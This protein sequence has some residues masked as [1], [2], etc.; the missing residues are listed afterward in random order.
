MRISGIDLFL[1]ITYVL[2]ILGSGAFGYIKAK[3]QEDYLV[4]GR[5][6]PL[7]VYIAC[8]STVVIGGGA[9]FGAATQGFDVGLSAMWM[10]T[11]FGVG[12]IALGFLLS[13]KLS[14][15]RIL[16]LSQM[17]E[18]RY[19]KYAS[20][21][22]AI[23]SSFYIIMVAVTNTIALGVAFSV[24][25]GW[26]L[27][28]SI[29]V[30]GALA[31]SYTMLGG[32]TSLAITDT[33]QFTLMTITI[34]FIL[35]PKGFSGVDGWSGLKA[36]LP[37]SYFDL[38]AVG[39][40]KIFSWFILFALGLT[41]GQDIWQR[42]FSAKN[43]KIAKKGTIIGGIYTIL[44]SLAMTL[45]GMMTLALLPSTSPQNA[46]S[47]IVIAIVPS[48]FRGLVF[49]G[50]MSA[51]LSTIAGCMLASSTLILHDIIRIKQHSLAK[52]RWVVIA[53][54]AVIIMVSVFVQNVLTALDITYAILSGCIFIP[55]IAAFF[56]KKANWQGACAS[57]GLSFLTVIGTMIYFTP[58]STIPILLGIS[59]NLITLVV[60]SL[61]TKPNDVEK[62][63]KWEERIS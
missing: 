11:M 44:W 54:G 26:S 38:F 33:I 24:I 46:L 60:V 18:I 4:A 63:Q 48:G 50:V 13:T 17:L 56:W 3:D 8:L 49:A 34:F 1:I 53:V 29:F 30:A 45:C 62:M 9:T 51:F 12:I 21:I 35:L 55:V 31:L 42:V 2:I 47:E 40:T 14:N 19:N 10:V 41:I 28:F 16:T 57:M 36:S 6:L 39:Y 27:E 59:V 15:L 43:A 32:M 7:P 5:K 37:E 22:S 25:M 58:S 61:L 20:L 23:I 52:T